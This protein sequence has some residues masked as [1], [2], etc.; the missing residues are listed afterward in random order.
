VAQTALNPGDGGP[1]VQRLGWTFRIG[2]RAIQTENDYNRD[3]F[4]GDLGIIEEINRIEQDMVVTFEG[5]QVEYDFGDMDELAPHIYNPTSITTLFM[6][7]YATRS[8][9]AWFVGGQAVEARRA[10]KEG[11][12]ESS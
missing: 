2:D 1:E 9:V 12:H 6:P 5:R 4:N 7:R 8:F 10:R 11:P 3:V